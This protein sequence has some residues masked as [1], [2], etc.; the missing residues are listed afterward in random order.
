MLNNRSNVI[1]IQLFFYEKKYNLSANFSF[2]YICIMQMVKRI[3][4]FYIFSNIHVAFAVFSLTKITLLTYNIDSN[5]LPLFVFFSTLA[6]Y[7]FIRLYKIYKIKR[8]F[9]KFIR[10]NKKKILVLTIVSALLAIY[11]GLSLNRDAL[12]AL[13]PFGLFTLFYVVPIPIRRNSTLAL[14]KVAFLKLFLIAFS[15]AGVTVLIPLVN[16]DIDIQFNNELIIFVQRF[17]FVI[18]IT[19]PFDIRDM[20]FDDTRIKTLPQVISIQKSKVFGL[21]LLMVFMGLE[22]L[23]IPNEEVQFSIHLIIALLSLLLLFR[24]TVLQGRYYSAFFVESLPIV[25]LLLVVLK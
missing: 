5:L 12:L 19:I 3:F 13:L 10:D 1:K 25:W 23:K 7:N 18:V 22:F 4:D 8:W 9:F 21:F 6:S 15:W 16:Y 17:L 11:L 2:H 20:N 24:A 14:R